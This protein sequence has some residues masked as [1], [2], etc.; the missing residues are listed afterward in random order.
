LNH[1]LSHKINNKEIIK[2][3]SREM[4]VA[5]QT[6]ATNKQSNKK[7]MNIKNFVNGPI[8]KI[9]FLSSYTQGPVIVGA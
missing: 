1:T 9:M 5:R 7:K 3:R 2:S 8:V 4:F 6:A